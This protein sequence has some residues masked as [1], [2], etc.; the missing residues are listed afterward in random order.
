MVRGQF[1]IVRSN[2]TRVDEV[3]RI[4]D[5]RTVDPEALVMP[6]SSGALRLVE[7]AGEPLQPNVTRAG[8]LLAGYRLTVFL[9]HDGCDG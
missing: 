6:S 3:G 1:N 2:V 4:A 8:H 7:A 5:H 9:L